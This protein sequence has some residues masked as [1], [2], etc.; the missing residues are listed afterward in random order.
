MNIALLSPL[1]QKWD[2]GEDVDDDDAR[3]VH[4][5]WSTILCW[6]YF[7]GLEYMYIPLFELL[8]HICCRYWVYGLYS[9]GSYY[10]YIPLFELLLH[11]C[12]RYSCCWASNMVSSSWIHVYSTIWVVVTHLLWILLLLSVK[13]RISE[14]LFLVYFWNMVNI[15]IWW[16]MIR[17]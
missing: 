6:L 11:I 10:M 17:I 1:M 2:M 5:S 4:D 3:R 9:R 16:R 12:C 14:G 8:L 7:V 13:Y 15:R